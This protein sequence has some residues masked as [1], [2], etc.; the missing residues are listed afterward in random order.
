MSTLLSSLE[1]ES[2][3]NS[4]NDSNL[5]EEDTNE[6]SIAALTP[7]DSNDIGELQR[8]MED[9]SKCPPDEKTQMMI[10]LCFV[11]VDG[12]HSTVHLSTTRFLKSQRGCTSRS[13]PF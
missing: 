4:T 11:Y 6:S 8:F 9:D 12:F 13:F 7:N 10:N 3:N 5:E 1:V 2:N